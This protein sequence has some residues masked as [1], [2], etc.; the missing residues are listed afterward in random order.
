MGTSGALAS[1]RF[2]SLGVRA[3]DGADPSCFL[4]PIASY[5]FGVADGLRVA[6]GLGARMDCPMTD[7][8]GTRE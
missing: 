2:A 8:S 6:A 7:R 3:Q 4:P 5:G 1:L